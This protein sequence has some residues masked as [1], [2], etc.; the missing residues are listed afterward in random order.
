MAKRYMNIDLTAEERAELLLA[1][2]S[3]EEKMGQV[4]CHLPNDHSNYEK[5]KEDNPNGC[6]MISCLEM[7]TLETIEEVVQFQKEVQMLVMDMSEHNIPAIF[8]M[9]GLCGG[10]FQGATSFPSGIGRASTWNPELEEEIGRIVGREERMIGVTQTF[11]PVLDISRDSRM[12]RQG[13]TYGEDPVLAAA[14]GSAFT[15][16]L[17][18]EEDTITGLKTDAVAKHFLGFHA[19]FGGIHGGDCD[20]SERQLREIYGKPFQAAI[21]ESGLK[22]IMPCY[23]SINGQAVS[24]NKEIMTNMLRGEMGFEGLTVSDYCAVMNI[25]TVQHGAENFTEA[26]LLSMDAGMDA[27][28]HFKKTFN[29]ELAE[30]FRSGKAD[31]EILNTAVRRILTAKFRMGLFEN[32]FAQSS[33]V[34][35]TV[36]GK[37]AHKEVT[38]QSALESLILLKNENNV[39]PISNKVKKITVVGYLASTA[40]IMY[41]GYTHFSM[42]EVMHAVT[43]TMA[44]VQSEKD[45]NKMTTIPG[46]QIE[47]DTGIFDKVLYLQNPEAKSLYEQIKEEFPNAEVDY[48]FG[49]HFAGDD[50]SKHDAALESCKDADIVILAL[51]GKHGVGSIASMGEGIDSTDINLPICQDTFIEKVAKLN[52]PLVGVHFNGRPIS[53][54]VADKYLDAILEAWN[55]SEAGSEAIVSV[56]KGDYNPGGKLPVSI[57]RVGGQIPIYYNHPYGSCYNQG[58]SISFPDYVDMPHTPR[59]YFGHGLSYTSFEYLNL[60]LE[61][62]ELHANET[63]LVSV[64]ITNTGNVKGEEVVQLYIKDLFASMTRPVQE[65]AGFKRI[66]LEPG[67]TKNLTFNVKLSQLAFL[68]RTMQ[69]KVESGEVEIQIGSSSYDIRLTDSYKVLDNE[70]VDGKNRGFYAAVVVK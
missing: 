37:K 19:A 6:G 63:L 36:V 48:S 58:D 43:N 46:T 3:V 54:D 68:D 52:K 49:F 31:I 29:D 35:K 41:G 10:F 18:D 42:A 14:L 62:K 26:G 69:W 16:G 21:S 8:H 7:R 28:L 56:L 1:E 9:E 44:G 39:L 22:G 61:N 27:E 57:A 67:E 34:I 47:E 20:I 2:L 4:V 12:G 45:P 11:A 23:N 64:D 32:P 70:Y 5:I 25:V 66:I 59:Y 24:A 38:K 15:R 53:S 60:Q 55:P 51:G 40:K 17:Q 33:E 50:M 65:L 30:W 13:E